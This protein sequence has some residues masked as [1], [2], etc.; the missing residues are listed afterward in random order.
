MVETIEH[1][2]PSALSGVEHAV[3]ALLCPTLVVMTTPNSEYNV[4]YGLAE[5][6]IR[7][8]DHRFEWGRARFAS[9]AGGVGRRNGYGVEMSMIGRPDPR[10]GS[11]TQM[12]T[13]RREGR[14]VHLAAGRA[15]AR[16]TDR[17]R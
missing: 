4:R 16:S 13:F 2:E 7:Q 3:F 8:P 9:W 15:P 1:V 17:I 5:G 11:P 6:E 12:A 14:D 10:L